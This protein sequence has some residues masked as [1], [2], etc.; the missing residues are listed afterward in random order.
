MFLSVM[1]FLVRI[2]SGQQQ[3]VTDSSCSEY[4]IPFSFQSDKIGNPTLLCTSPVCFDEKRLYELKRDDVIPE[5][6][7]ETKNLLFWKNH[8]HKAQCHKFYQNISCTEETQWTI[9]LLLEGDENNVKVKWKCCNYE[10]LRHARA[11]KTVI[12][13]IGES[14][15]GGEVYQNSRRVAFDLVKEVHLLH[16]EQHRPRYELKIMRLACIPKPIDIK[17]KLT[18]DKNSELNPPAIDVSS[19]YDTEEYVFTNQH[20]TKY[21][22]PRSRR[23]TILDDGN[24]D[25]LF[26][27]RHR[28]AHRKMFSLRRR[29]FYKPIAGDYDYYDYDPVILRRPTVHSRIIADG[30]WP[31]KL[32]IRRR[33]R[34]VV[35]A[36]PVSPALYEITSPN[37]IDGDYHQFVD[38]DNTAT[39]INSDQAEVY[40]QLS[41]APTTGRL[42]PAY[43][44]IQYIPQRAVIPSESKTVSAAQHTVPTY[45]GA[46][47]PYYG[48]FETLQCFSGDITVQTP[49]QIKRIDELEV[50]DQVL[51]IEES[52]ENGE[53]IKLTDYHLL[54][55]TGCTAGEKLRLTFAKD[56]R[57]GQCLHVVK[58]QSNNLVP[59][60]VSNIQRLT[61]K[62]FYAPL[63]A[64]GDIIV[65][66]ILSSCHSNIAMQ[67]LQQSIFSLLR[68]IRSLMFTDERTDGLLPGI[69]YLVQISELFLPHSII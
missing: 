47:V 5:T 50:G 33:N 13:K 53:V 14:Y 59:V 58:K 60:Q 63:T 46:T 39:P 69:Q 26:S 57:L 16:D 25:D 32:G 54:Y 4:T 61:G 11:I 15:T 1:L 40:S 49:D 30:L 21:S 38:S 43:S 2:T 7:T 48:Y 66:S 36:A 18:A 6:D 24:S 34:P 12:V 10:G 8:V 35:A 51:S 62:G 37:A 23:P 64:N 19:E 17:N 41:P 27:S 20:H 65:N 55:V 45:S 42:L 68:K 44:G 28:M 31:I 29:P 9:G 3:S 56:V 22:K 67:T 52:L